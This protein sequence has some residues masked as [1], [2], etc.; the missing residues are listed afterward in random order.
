[1]NFRRKVK[2]RK[3][4]WRCSGEILHSNLKFATWNCL[5]LGKTE[6]E[7]D[8]KL[9][10]CRLL[11][12]DVL[13]LTEL[14]NQQVE[15]FDFCVSSI[16]LSDRAAGVGLLF[17]EQIRPHVIR[18][19]SCGSR[20]VWARIRGPVCNLVVVGLYLP[21]AGK[22]KKPH[23][24]HVLEELHNLLDGLGRHECVLILGDLNAQLPRSVD[25]LTGKWT[26]SI[27][28]DDRNDCNG[29]M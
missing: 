2:R 5:A 26:H 19:G 20:I 15:K 24:H 21:H 11:G 28:G 25:G 1:M 16:N 18:T 12:Y 17:S 27:K 13:C 14:W 29:E 4:T 23:A 7:K 10:F 9:D 8:V 22:K 3:A 6:A